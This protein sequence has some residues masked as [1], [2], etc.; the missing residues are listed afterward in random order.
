MTPTETG[1]ISA[2]V[3][4]GLVGPRID[5]VGLL[6]D[7]I[8]ALLTPLDEQPYR[9]RQVFDW[10]QHQRITDFD[11]MSNLPKELRIKMAGLFTLSRM[12]P[13][14][15]MESRDG[16]T[17]LVFDIEGGAISSVLMPARGR[18][19]LCISSQVGCRM[20]CRFC[21]TGRMGRIRNLSSAE[22]VGQV[23][24]AARLVEPDSRVS[25]VVFMGM[26][27]PLDNLD[28]VIQTVR[29]ITHRE[30][31]RVAPRRTTIST[32]GLLPRLKEFLGAGTGASIAMSLCGTTYEIRSKM[33][34]A[35]KKYDL[36]GT[37]ETLRSLP[38]GHGHRYTVEYLLIDGV[39][40]TIDDAKRL[41]RMLARFPSK[42]N[43]I[44]FNPWPGSG[45]GRP[46]PRKI[47][48]FRQLLADKNHLVTVRESR[49]QDIGAACGQ[50]G[51]PTDG[52]SG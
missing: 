32:V 10:I 39:S 1:R 6:P 13:S 19:T 25:N 47:E 30:G 11:A 50:L 38:L 21:L 27:E 8:A 4:R 23:L 31:L 41:S 48:A 5:L 43:L 36:A 14:R 44:P 35:G 37:I 24:A 9:G 17:K 20:G 15:K 51:D 2:I 33:T 7:E 3:K 28:N 22:M 40:D 26:G 45:Y 42:V 34:P 12:E 29:I 16:S 49:G 18:V 46:D 52:E